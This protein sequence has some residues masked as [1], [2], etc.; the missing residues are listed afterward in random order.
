MIGLCVVFPRVF[1][2]RLTPSVA[3]SLNFVRIVFDDRL[4]W[5]DLS[6]SS[7]HCHPLCTRGVGAETERAP[8]EALARE[9][10][11]Y[12]VVGVRVCP[13]GETLIMKIGTKALF[14]GALMA[15]GMTANAQTFVYNATDV[16]G[17]Y[18]SFAASVAA[19]GAYDVAYT[20][21]DGFLN[22]SNSA[23]NA[24]Y[25]TTSMST[26]Q[27]ADSFRAQG[28]WDGTG[29]AGYGYGIARFQQFFTVTEDA[30]VTITW[31]TTD[32]DGFWS[33]LVA[34]DDINGTVAASL[35]GSADAG[36]FS[37]FADNDLNYVFLG[38]LFNNGFGPFITAD[39]RSPAFIEVTISEVPAPGAAALLGLAGVAGLRRRRA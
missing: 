11:T 30:I 20:G 32:T 34:Q 10:N 6:V 9:K 14:G 2:S 8:R 28:S 25:G 19:G 27:D 31:D 35:G 12:L 29:T 16:T 18:P 17:A 21:V 26:S 15:A 24:A 7:T 37:F 4:C 39:A 3:P 33:A 22:T 38:G 13:E 5:G 1:F 23:Y 36:S